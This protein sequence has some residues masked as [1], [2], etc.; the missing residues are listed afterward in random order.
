MS[1]LP[2]NPRLHASHPPP[3]PVHWHT[4]QAHQRQQWLNTQG[5]LPRKLARN[6]L[7]SLSHH[8]ADHICLALHPYLSLRLPPVVHRIYPSPPPPQK[9]NQP[10]QCVIITRHSTGT[11]DSQNESVQPGNAGQPCRMATLLHPVIKSCFSRNSPS[12]AGGNSLYNYKRPPL[13]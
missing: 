2:H 1:C 9:K 7:F 11:L 10:H 13:M 6:P 4:L 8:L 3:P 5:R 12:Q